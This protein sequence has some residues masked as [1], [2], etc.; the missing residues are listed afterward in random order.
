MRRI[1]GVIGGFL[2][3]MLFGC[4]AQE[5]QI[6]HELENMPGITCEIDDQGVQHCHPDD[7]NTVLNHY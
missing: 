6:V 3:F 7:P 4:T 1:K 2:V 5:K